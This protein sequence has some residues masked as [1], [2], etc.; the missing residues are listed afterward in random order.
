MIHAGKLFDPA[1]VLVLAGVTIP[2]FTEDGYRIAFN[3]TKTLDQSPDRARCTIFGLGPEERAAIQAVF[4]EIGRAPMVVSAGY[5]G[6]VSTIFSGGVRH[7]DPSRRIGV[8]VVT[9][10]Q[11]DDA[12]DEIAEV[13]ITLY[14]AEI[15]VRQMVKVAI[16]AFAAAGHSVSEHPSV[17]QA[18]GL[19]DPFISEQGWTTAH[20]GSVASLL[21]QAARIVG[22]RW[23]IRSNQLYFSARNLPLEA[24][25]T[26][27]FRDYWLAEPSEDGLGLVRLPIFFEPQIEPGRPVVVEGITYRVEA[28]M[29]AGDTHSGPWSTSMMMRRVV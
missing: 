15:T 8:D 3:V 1:A 13:N 4:G 11:G 19:A 28:A 14:G 7:M 10:V 5:E 6:I 12:G 27:I 26:V 21:D 17:E 25:P 16:G 24:I 18:I 22:A 9:Y 23:F 29:H 20:N 2:T